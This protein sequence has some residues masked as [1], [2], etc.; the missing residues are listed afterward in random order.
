MAVIKGFSVD[1]IQ[2]PFGNKDIER[3]REWWGQSNNHGRYLWIWC[4]IKSK[5]WV[6]ED[7]NLQSGGKWLWVLMKWLQSKEALNWLQLNLIGKY[8]FL[9]LI[10]AQFLNFLSHLKCFLPFFIWFPWSFLS[11]LTIR[12]LEISNLMSGPVSKLPSENKI[13]LPF[14]QCS[15]PCSLSINNLLPANPFFLISPVSAPFIP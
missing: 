1:W 3:Q 13:L 15:I 8:F 5:N 12:T 14:L 11:I 7:S 2:K 4:W 9:A 10:W 6:Q